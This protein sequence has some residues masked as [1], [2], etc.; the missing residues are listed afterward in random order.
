MRCSV[1]LS[2]IFVLACQVQA[3]TERTK[4]DLNQVQQQLKDTNKTFKEQ[5]ILLNQIELDLKK[6]DAAIAASSKKLKQLKFDVELNLTEQATLK[7]KI[8][9]LENDKANQ[10][11]A[12]AAQLK[13]AFM[14]GNHDYGKL[15]LSQDQV[16]D[17]ERTLNYYQ[18]L[19]NARIKELEKLKATLIE[20][21][22][23][24]QLLAQNQS[25]LEALLKTQ[26][27][28]QN[29]LLAAK[30]EQKEKYQ[31]LKNTLQKTQSQLVYLKQNEQVLKQ[32]LEQLSH[33][34][35]QSEVKLDGLQ[36]RKGKLDW[37]S[38]G[39]LT[40]RFGQRKHGSLKWKGVLMSGKEGAP[41]KTIADGQ[42]LF[43]DW[44]KGF[45]WVIVVDHGKGFM[46]LYGHSQALLKE[47]GDK[48]KAGEQIALVGQSGGQSN[49]SL[50]FEIR[51]KGRAVNPVKWCRRI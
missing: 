31:T 41:V 24:R 28:Q 29:A 51:H 13:S 12:L 2:V 6:A 46:S 17:V 39:K 20:L 10:Q 25:Q 16:Q 33:D 43:A 49:P 30:K 27:E 3:N 48:V 19:N 5:Q 45:G 15:L 8:K 35:A 26:E 36:A 18:Y 47:V 4:D 14:T 1:L 7:D 32:T 9:S 21:E 22:N 38:R 42:V 23:S 44:L 37:P 50:Y 11:A 34:L 40:H